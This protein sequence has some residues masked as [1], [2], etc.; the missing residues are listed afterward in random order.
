MTD[1]LLGKIEAS[2]ESIKAST[3]AANAASAAGFE[4]VAKTVED[5]L[6]AASKAAQ[7]KFGTLYT[8]MATQRSELD[9]A[10][11]SA[12]I[13]IND[14][15]AKQAALADSR[16]SKTVKDLA[17]ARTAAAAD[18]KLARE[19]F[20]TA[21]EGVTDEIKAMDTKMEA[22]V[23]VVAAEF[24]KTQAMQDTVNMHVQAEIARIEK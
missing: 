16:F 3:D 12:T 19:Q 7:D 22:R 18:V 10:L 8:D 2:S 5:E 14:E 24:V 6:A 1:S 4:A 23:Q 15:I 20:A 11:G 13:T 17:A 9:E 21:L